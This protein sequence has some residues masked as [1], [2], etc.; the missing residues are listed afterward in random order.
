MAE[1]G[2]RFQSY[3]R[4]FHQGSTLGHMGPKIA[5]VIAKLSSYSTLFFRFG[6]GPSISY[7]LKVLT[8]PPS[9][10]DGFLSA[11][12]CGLDTPISSPDT[13]CNVP[14]CTITRF[15]KAFSTKQK[16]ISKKKNPLQ[17]RKCLHV[18]PEIHGM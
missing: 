4:H 15:K 5:P 3:P 11:P 10:Y 12:T 18:T 17:Q 1:G 7:H 16:S 8:F 9:R 14:L 6:L 13:P 2:Q